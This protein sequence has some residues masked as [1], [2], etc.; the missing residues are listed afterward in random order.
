MFTMLLITAVVMFSITVVV[1]IVIWLAISWFFGSSDVRTPH[2]PTRLRHIER[3]TRRQMHR[4]ARDY[5]RTAI[6]MLERRSPY[7]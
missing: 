5:E 7:E 2:Y 4:L 6:D 1:G 3:D